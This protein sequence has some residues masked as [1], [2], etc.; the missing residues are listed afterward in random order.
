MNILLIEDNSADAAL[1]TVRVDGGRIEGQRQPDSAVR[2]FLGIPYAA[3]PT[4][5]LQTN[6]NGP[7]LFELEWGLLADELAFVPGIPARTYV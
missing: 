3:A 4:G 1:L 7:D 2:A 6:A 5:E